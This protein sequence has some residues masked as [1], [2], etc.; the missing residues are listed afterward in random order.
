MLIAEQTRLDG[1]R[2]I[3]VEEHVWRHTRKGDTY[4]TGSVSDQP[5]MTQRLRTR[6]G[7]GPCGASVK[8]LHRP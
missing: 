1:V 6:S 3:G 7:R 8:G 5:V 4:V 2:V